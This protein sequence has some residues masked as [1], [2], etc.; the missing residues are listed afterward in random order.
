MDKLPFTKFDFWGYLASGF[1]LL[2]AVDSAAHSGLLRRENWT[3]VEGILAVSVAYVLGHIVAG[4]SSVVLE[5]MVVHRVLGWPSASLFGA[6]KAPK[7][8][9][10]LMRSY[11][12]ALPAETQQAVLTK[13]SQVGVA[14]PGEALFWL[15]FAKARSNERTMARVSDFLNQYSFCRNVAMVLLIDGCILWWAHL[16]QDGTQAQLVW[17]RAAGAGGVALFFRYLKFLRHYSVEL[18]ASFAYAEEP[19]AKAP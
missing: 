1:L 12:S 3:I 10:R 13:A 15:V 9:Q 7:W 18:F 4:V 16:Q 2:C 14:R 17:A 8:L 5:R 19:K 6:S 11:Y